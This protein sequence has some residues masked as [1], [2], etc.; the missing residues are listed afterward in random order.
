MKNLQ[1]GRARFLGR[2]TSSTAAKCEHSAHL[3][4]LHVLRLDALLLQHV[5]D[6]LELCAAGNAR[7]VQPSQPGGGRPC[8]WLPQAGTV[9]NVRQQTMQ[10][11]RRETVAQRAGTQLQSQGWHVAASISAP[12]SSGEC[13]KAPPAGRRQQCCRKARPRCPPFCLSYFFRICCGQRAGRMELNAVCKNGAA[14]RPRARW[15]VCHSH[16]AARQTDNSPAQQP[17]PASQAWRDPPCA[18]QP[19][20]TG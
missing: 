6:G 7:G 13:R 19:A 20:A 15:R 9:S 3:A 11:E 17:H 8:I 10:P 2:A 16:Q 1:H 14:P 12:S 18:A 5:L 4:Q